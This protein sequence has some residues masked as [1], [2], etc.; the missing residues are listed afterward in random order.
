MGFVFLIRP[1]NGVLIMLTLSLYILIDVLKDRVS[2]S[3]AVSRAV[4]RLYPVVA[5][6]ILMLLIFFTHNYA[7]MGHPL[8]TQY[9]TIYET[10]YKNMFGFSSVRSI[11][12]AYSDTYINITLMERILTGWPYGVALTLIAFSLLLPTVR[13][14]EYL[15]WIVPV[16]IICGY[17]L[18]RGAWMMYGPRF[19][20]ETVPFLLL[21]IVAGIEKFSVMLSGI[22]KGRNAKVI[23]AKRHLVVS[24]LYSV[25]L[26]LS[27]KSMQNWYQIRITNLPAWGH[28]Y[29]PR[30]IGDMKSF[31]FTHTDVIQAVKANQIH[32]AV[33]FVRPYWSMKTFSFLMNTELSDDVVYAA[34]VSEK[35]NNMLMTLYPG[36]KYY[37]GD[38]ETGELT[39]Y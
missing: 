14:E 33:I 37:R 38:Y 39:V 4:S 6:L 10:Q 8:K 17:F 3:R 2:L 11:K 15:L 29:T 30:N 1:Y 21:V 25:V 7:T 20:Y 24:F 5:G 34:D 35:E 27:V 16:S 26:I 19:W 32:N 31:N 36:R 18:Y 22:F 13:R 23:P 28:D 9:S 12:N